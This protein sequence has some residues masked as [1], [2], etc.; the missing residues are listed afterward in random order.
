M[1]LFDE[2]L[3]DAEDSIGLSDMPEVNKESQANLKRMKKYV[4][5]LKRLK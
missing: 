5:R 4:G 2:A 1:D 3:M